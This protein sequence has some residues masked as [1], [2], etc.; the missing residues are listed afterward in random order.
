MRPD[1]T[2]SKLVTA[3]LGTSVLFKFSEVAIY[4]FDSQVQ[5]KYIV[6]VQN[7]SFMVFA[8]VK[9]FMILHGG[10]LV[11]FAWISMIEAMVVALLMLSMLILNGPK[12]LYL[13]ASF[14]TAKKLLNDSWPLMLSN[15]AIM[16]YMKID[17][18]M[19]G[20]MVGD[21][22]VGIYSAASRI[23]EVWYFIPMAVV[24]SVFPALLEAKK[25]S[26]DLYYER[27]QRLYGLM[28][29][30]SLTVALP[31]TFLAKPLVNLL[32]GEAY[33]ESG[34]VLAIHIWASVF[35]FLGVASSNWFIAENRQILSLQRTVVGMLINIVLNLLLIPAY[36][37]V[38]AA[39]ATVI[40]QIS[41]G[42]AY[43]ALQKETQPMFLM[44]LKAFN[45]LQ[46]NRK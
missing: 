42:I 45:P 34:I 40:A 10:T 2:L 25:K 35:V 21:K 18:I 27:L 19:L 24:G 14:A 17:Q 4:W 41:V 33:I 8:I 39:V 38:G 7:G 13:I 20:Q 32:Y 16:V 12:P 3:I 23:S 46:L 29:W 44:K 28:V 37:V 11:A 9:I 6:W 43:D 22:A 1:D 30:M 31:M 36:G 26:Q 15:I 5:S